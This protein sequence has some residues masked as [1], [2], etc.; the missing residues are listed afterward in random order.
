MHVIDLTVNNSFVHM[1][2]F[3][4]FLLL[5]YAGLGAVY[6]MAFGGLK[7]WNFENGF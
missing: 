2:P 4:R 7:M 1:F 3:F 5:T 6:V